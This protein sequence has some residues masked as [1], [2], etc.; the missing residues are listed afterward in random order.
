MEQI[1]FTKLLCYLK[2]FLNLKQDFP[3]IKKGLKQLQEGLLT[4]LDHDNQ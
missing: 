3:N 4:F 2:F 1:V